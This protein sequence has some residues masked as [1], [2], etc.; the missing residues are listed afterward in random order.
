[1]LHILTTAVRPIIDA[2]ALAIENSQK[3][4][5]S[6]ITFQKRRICGYFRFPLFCF[7]EKNLWTLFVL[8]NDS[9]KIVPGKIPTRKI[10]THQTPPGKFFPKTFPPRKFPSG[11]FPHPFHQLSFFT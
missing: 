10:P 11:I 2:F 5:F 6:R 4:M 9:R 7:L 3:L 1:M 8:H